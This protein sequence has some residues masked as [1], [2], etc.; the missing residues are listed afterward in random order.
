MSISRSAAQVV[1]RKKLAEV[2]WKVIEDFCKGCNFCIE[3]CPVNALE[4]SEKLN[5]KGVHP[6][7]LK[8]EDACIGC[9]LCET[10][11]PDFAIHLDK[12]ESDEEQ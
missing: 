8:S 3:F 11:C 12:K 2:E 6:P 5:A 4:E 9:G 7:K 10:I 1:K